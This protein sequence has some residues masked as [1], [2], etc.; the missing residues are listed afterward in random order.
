MMDEKTTLRLM[1]WIVGSI[2]L[3]LFALNAW[4]LSS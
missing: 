3:A 4:A 2:V 1:V